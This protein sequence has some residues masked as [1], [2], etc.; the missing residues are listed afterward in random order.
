MRNDALAAR[1]CVGTELDE[2]TGGLGPAAPRVMAEP[3]PAPVRRLRD[4]RQALQLQGDVGGASS[5]VGRQPRIGT[6][7]FA[8][9]GR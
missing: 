5:S 9:S 8:A 3:P 7:L 1:L 6:A 2:R 4:V